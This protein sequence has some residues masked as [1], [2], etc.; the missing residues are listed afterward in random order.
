MNIN[1]G[2]GTNGGA[3]DIGGGGGGAGWI[4]VNT[5]GQPT[6]SGAVISPATTTTCYSV[7][8]L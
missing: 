4:R 6:L 5:S 8:T 3:S 1:G 7:G 2:N